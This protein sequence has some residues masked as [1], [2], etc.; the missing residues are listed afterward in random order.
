MFTESGILDGGQGRV[1]IDVARAGAVPQF[2]NVVFHIGILVFFMRARFEIVGVTA[3][4][5]RLVSGKSPEQRLRI[6]GVAIGTI[7]VATVLSGI[8]RRT[9]AKTV[10]Q[11]GR[12]GMATAA[13]QAGLEM[14]VIL[15]GC[16]GS[17]VTTLAVAGYTAVIEVGGLPRHR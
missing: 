11:P 9:V 7:E 5:C 3:G 6:I 12:G 8:V 17:V 2:G 10:W 1:G 16:G 13:V 15:A 14:A 4:A